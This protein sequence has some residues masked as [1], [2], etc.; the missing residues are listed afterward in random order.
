MAHF[1]ARL[2]HFAAV[3]MVAL[4]S[5]AFSTAPHVNNGMLTADQRREVVRINHAINYRFAHYDQ[6]GRGL[7]WWLAWNKRSALI[8]AGIPASAMALRDVQSPWGLHELLDVAGVGALDMNND[9]PEDAAEE[10][11]MGYGPR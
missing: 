4:A 10:R 9:W 8:A 3:C 1:K 7:C 2:L 5:E 6:N 11:R